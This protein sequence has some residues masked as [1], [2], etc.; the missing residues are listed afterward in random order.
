MSQLIFQVSAIAS[1]NEPLV[2]GTLSVPIRSSDNGDCLSTVPLVGRGGA[3]FDRRLVVRVVPMNE[4]LSLAQAG[5][6][7]ATILGG[8]E[9]FR[10]KELPRNG[11]DILVSE[12]GAGLI[13]LGYEI[14]DI[15]A[16][17]N[18]WI[19]QREL[20]REG[21]DISLDGSA[22]LVGFAE[23]GAK[24]VGEQLSVNLVGRFNALSDR[25][26]SL[27]N[28]NALQAKTAL[29]V[30]AGSVGSALASDLARSGVG[31]FA[32][33][34]HERL[35]WGNVVRHAAGL[36]DA[37]RL[38]TRIVAELIIDRN[39]AAEVRE[40]PLAL[41]S[42]SKETF[43]EVVASADV[44]IC[45]TDTRSSRLL[46]NRLCVRHKKTVIF[47]GLTNG[48]YGGMVFRFRPPD[49]MCYQ[50]FVSSFPDMAADRETDQSD[51]AGGPDGHLALDIA[52]IT[53]LMGKLAIVE[54]Q[55]QLGHVPGALD[56][57][58]AFPWYIWI[59]RREKEYAEI[60]TLGTGVAGLKILQW[61]PVPMDKVEGCPHCGTLSE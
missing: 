15:G 33:A 55:R 22:A 45:A 13:L 14:G 40:L 1:G 54:L 8:V 51:Y 32:V 11:F 43:D 17:N 34:E 56:A 30:G 53:N 57:D 5:R 50:C 38:K 26:G 48:A 41:E 6:A 58:L 42:T 39:P 60:P 31:R 21:V 36:S 23:N 18:F 10:S 49:T 46:C 16:S 44:V 19:V 2:E 27:V 29:I 61:N 25:D 3:S 24:A 12:Y 9:R 7:T 28:R 37:G 52:P 59:N 20:R 4:T 35:E 47:G